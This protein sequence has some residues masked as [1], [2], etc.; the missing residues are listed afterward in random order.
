MPA[1]AAA[2]TRGPRPPA[3]GGVTVTRA[4]F[5][6]W[7]ALILRN[8]AAEVTVVPAIGRIMQIALVEGGAAR[9]PLW[10]HPG[11]GPTLAPD[12][13]GWVNLGG[14]MT[15]VTAPAIVPF[16]A[17]LS[18]PADLAYVVA[19]GHVG[20]VHEGTSFNIISGGSIE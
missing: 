3:P 10:S 7:E 4:T 20:F 18:L 13:G 1:C 9:G 11:I 8:G 15:E 17:R 19:K 5:A 12:E 14:Y 16:G 2:R 6:G